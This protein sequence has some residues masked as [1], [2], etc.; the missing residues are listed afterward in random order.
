M[1]GQNNGW[2]CHWQPSLW[3]SG[4]ALLMTVLAGFA[5]SMS[6]IDWP[7]KI[8]V[9]T[10][11]ALQS[12]DQLLRLRRLQQP[13]QRRGIRQNENGWQIWTAQ[14]GWQSAQLRADSMAIPVL[15][16]LRYRYAHQWFYRTLVIGAD[17]LP[18]DS[19]RRLRVRLKFSRQR[20]RAVR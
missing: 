2:A 10:L 9:L 14:Q 4:L 5:V 12:T 11:L 3:L 19:H 16:L 7:W 13:S 8:G 1:R 20:W 17:S 6:A 18:V 15:V